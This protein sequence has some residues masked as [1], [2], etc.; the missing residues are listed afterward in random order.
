MAFLAM[1]RDSW[2]RR[3]PEALSMGHAPNGTVMSPIF[4]KLTGRD[5]IRES[6]ASLFKSFPDWAFRDDEPLIDGERVAVPFT[7]SATHAGRFIGLE[8][9]GRH[10]EIQ[11]VLLMDL[12]DGLIA[13][14]RRIYDFTGLLMQCGVLRGKPAT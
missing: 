9:T 5:A 6:Y 14:E 11:G 4:A 8:G 12:R 1:Q 13:A 2:Q 3:D 10:C 7:A